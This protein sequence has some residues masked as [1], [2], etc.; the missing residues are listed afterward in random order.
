MSQASDHGS[1][2]QQQTQPRKMTRRRKVL[3]SA[4]MLATFCAIAE[5]VATFLYL[6]GFLE[7]HAMWVHEA[8]GRGKTVRFDP[9]RGFR[10]TDQSSRNLVMTTHGLIES[11]GTW[12]GNNQGF[13]DRDDFFPKRPEGVSKRIAVFGDSF[14]AA[15]YI[16]RNW[17]DAVEDRFRTMKQP[18]QLLNFAIDGG[19]LANWWSTL[20]RL[21]KHEEYEIDGIIFA[22]FMGNV[23]RT[24]MF[25]DQA[26]Q[27]VDGEMVESQLMAAYSSGWN[28]RDWPATAEE[29][30]PFLGPIAEFTVSSEQFERA[31][32][33][34]W[35]PS[36]DRPFRFYLA[37]RCR[38]GLEELVGR[39][40]VADDNPV[41][42]SQR[43]L[44]AF[45]SIQSGRMKLIME[46][47]EYVRQKS[48]PVMVVHIPNQE[49]L[50]DGTRN[51]YTFWE[52]RSFARLLKAE[53][54]D[55]AKAF[56]GMSTSDIRRGW[57][58]FDGHWGQPCS[59]RFAEFMVDKLKNWPR[60]RGSD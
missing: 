51:E 5:T 30:R 59:D 43:T 18:A 25:A 10:L 50:Y 17:P 44:S 41:V 15:Q 36:I 45:A 7:P 56:A 21:V 16:E 40:D 13:P 34:N 49:E 6:R 4:V 31:L 19:G 48:L 24:F 8:T 39:W 55:G 60:P 3:F 42:P 29:A 22:V 53:F 1:Q 57:L 26:D 14:T 47:Q 11:V 37:N 54:V 27:W 58:V 28:P 9:I 32:S 33:G 35:R 38:R 52:T 12:Q 2:S 46:I 23:G 20:I